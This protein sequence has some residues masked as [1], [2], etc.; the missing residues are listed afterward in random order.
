VIANLPELPRRPI[1]FAAFDAEEVGA[2]GSRRFADN[3]RERDQMPFVINLD[4]A[5]RFHGTVWGTS[6]SSEPLLQALD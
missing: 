6:P 4:G 3:L 1:L 5:A 2:V